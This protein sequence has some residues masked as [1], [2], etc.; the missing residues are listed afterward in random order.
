MEFS[1]QEYWSRLPFPTPGDL[2]DHLPSMAVYLSVHHLSFHPSFC[3]S[4]HLSLSPS[5]HPC[6]HSYHS[7]PGTTLLPEGHLTICMLPTVVT[8]EVSLASSGWRP[9]TLFS[10]PDLMAPPQNTTQPQMSVRL[11][12]RT[13]EK[14]GGETPPPRVRWKKLQAPHSTPFCPQ[15]A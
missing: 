10:T 4:T 15:A 13:S 1:R 9:G 11:R 5:I 14:R 8:R 6:L 3:L 12:V 7:Q 2:P